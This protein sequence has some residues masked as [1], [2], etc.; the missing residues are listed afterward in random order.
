MVMVKR[1]EFRSQFDKV[2][3]EDDMLESAKMIEE[4]MLISSLL[5]PFYT[6]QMT[7]KA[8]TVLDKI[9]KQIEEQRK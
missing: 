2:E 1:R 9:N 4:L 6:D 5:L 7:D 3:F 8:Y